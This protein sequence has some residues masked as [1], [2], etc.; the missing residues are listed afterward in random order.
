[1]FYTLLLGRIGLIPH[2]MHFFS[3]VLCLNNSTWPG[4]TRGGTYFL[5]L[6]PTQ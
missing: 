4:E 1:M 6:T 2:Q 5:P 3:Q